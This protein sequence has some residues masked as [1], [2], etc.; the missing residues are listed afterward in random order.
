MVIS[1]TQYLAAESPRMA[2][3][4]PSGILTTHSTEY[5]S[6]EPN[7]HSLLSGSVVRAVAL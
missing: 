6:L 7:P 2:P 3:D 4:S 5:T 1:R